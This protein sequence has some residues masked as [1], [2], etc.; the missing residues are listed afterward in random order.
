MIVRPLSGTV[1]ETAG[2]VP[3]AMM[4]I[5]ASKSARAARALHA[6]VRGVDETGAPDDH[7]DAVA[8]ELRLRDVDFGLDHLVDAEAEVRHR[9]LFLHVV[10]DA[11]DALELEA[12]KMQH[13]FPHGLAGDRAGVDA[14]AADD[15]PL[16]DHRHLA[17]AL[18]ALNGRALSRGSGPDDDEVVGLHGHAG[19]AAGIQLA[20]PA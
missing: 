11:V 3:V 14:R 12:G 19:R 1:G 8:R 15:F 13:R 4:M 20:P 7:L 6:D 18:R 2:L 9:D 17:P 16:L 10:V 5:G